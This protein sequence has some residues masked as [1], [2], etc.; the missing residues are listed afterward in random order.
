MRLHHGAHARFALHLGLCL[1]EE[2]STAR[3]YAGRSEIVAEVDLDIAGLTV[4][5]V[6]AY[7]RN[8]NDA[9]GD[10]EADLTALAARGV[11]V[12]VY[13]DEDPH[14]QSHET[15]RIVSARALAA[16]TVVSVSGGEGDDADA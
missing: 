12:L 10:T 4:E 11:D 13:G 2:R 16:L 7:D 9:A 14:G 8:A 1:A 5:R 15:Y 6:A 3:R